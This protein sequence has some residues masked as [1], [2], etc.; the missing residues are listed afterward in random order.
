[1]KDQGLIL[2]TLKKDYPGLRSFLSSIYEG[3]FTM[4]K[5]SQSMNLTTYFGAENTWN[6]S[7]LTHIFTVLCFEFGRM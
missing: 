1:M 4:K 7:G 5:G 2:I 6:P 3:S